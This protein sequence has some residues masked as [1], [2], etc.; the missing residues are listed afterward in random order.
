MPT[1]NPRFFEQLLSTSISRHHYTSTAE[2]YKHFLDTTNQLTSTLEQAAL[3]GRF[4]TNMSYAFSAGY[5]S[6]IQSLFKPNTRSLSSVCITEKEGNH[7]RNIKSTLTKHQQSWQLNGSKSF[8]TGA[9]DAKR[10]YIAV[11]DKPASDKHTNEHLEKETTE[12]TVSIRPKIKMLSVPADQLGINIAPMPPLPFVPDIS[13]GIATFEHVNIQATQI[14]EG[15][16]YSQYI[17]PFRTHEDIHVLA[18][19]IGFRIGEAMDSKWAQSSVE[20]HLMLLSSLLSLSTDNFSVPTTHIIFSGCRAQF[21]ALIQQTDDEFKQNNAEG[22]SHW[23]RD[24]AL[25]DIAN[26]AHILRTD[27]AWDYI[28][29]S[30]PSD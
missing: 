14:L 12:R 16:G 23:K 4:S 6:A 30:H 28:L 29:K 2:W 1:H 22:F 13:H 18:A 7:P 8:I 20:A 10:L 3:G 5:Q 9:N 26:K 21:S 11:T 25:L 17:K 19:I 24:K 15:D 27:R